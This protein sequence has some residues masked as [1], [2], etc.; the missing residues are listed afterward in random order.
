MAVPSEALERSGKT[1]DVV[2]HRRPWRLATLANG[3]QRVAAA[4]PVRL[5]DGV[6]DG[7]DV[8]VTGPVDTVDG[9]AAVAAQARPAISAS[10]MS[11]ERRWIRSPALRGWSG[12]RPELIPVAVTSETATPF[13]DGDPM[14]GQLGGHQMASSGS[15][16]LR[17]WSTASTTVTA[18][19]RR[20]EILGRL[21]TDEP[22]PDD[23]GCRRL[24]LRRR[25]PVARHPRRS[26]APGP[27]RSPVWGDERER[28]RGSTPAC[29]T[30]IDS[31]GVVESGTDGHACG[32]G[33]RYR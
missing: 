11:G 12:C 33:R 1:A 15:S 7:I 9:D 18:I 23:H 10:R 14:G 2:G 20:D 16:G 32:R 30:P 3:D 17:T 19:D 22:G 6:S 28:H 29:R 24:S 26:E 8:L 13:A 25:R 31:V 5:L 4:H 21:Q 27:A